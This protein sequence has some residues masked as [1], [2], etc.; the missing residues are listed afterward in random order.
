[1]GFPGFSPLTLTATSTER[2]MRQIISML[3]VRPQGGC[4][5]GERCRGSE[6]MEK[7]DGRSAKAS[8]STAAMVRPKPLK[9]EREEG[10]LNSYHRNTASALRA[11]FK[12]HLQ[13]FISVALKHKH[14]SSALPTL[15]PQA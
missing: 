3:S 4:Q 8:S 12:H 13:I 11:T 1:M 2:M 10:S 15:H 14:G 9:A 7:E 6:E 5:A